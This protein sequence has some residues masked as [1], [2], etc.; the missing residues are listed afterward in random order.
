MQGRLYSIAQSSRKTGSRKNER[1][2]G[3]EEVAYRALLCV[4]IAITD[5]SGEGRIC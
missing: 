4:T 2:K 3:R 5:P 1:E